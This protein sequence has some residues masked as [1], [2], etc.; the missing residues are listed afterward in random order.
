MSTDYVKE[1]QSISKGYSEE[2]A[3]KMTMILRYLKKP[4]HSVRCAVVGGI[5][6]D[7]RKRHY[8][9]EKKHNRNVVIVFHSMSGYTES[10]SKSFQTSELRSWFSEEIMHAKS[11]FRCPEDTC[12]TSRYQPQL[13][14]ISTN[15]EV[16]E[17]LES[18]TD[19]SFNSWGG[20]V[21][22][23]TVPQILLILTTQSLT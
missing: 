20:E 6:L 9:K 16:T 7:V 10:H 13:G 21:A 11:Q 17:W 3:V 4:D 15:K 12:K 5:S 14:E 18:E 1:D 2:R 23:E 19:Q 22:M 8:R